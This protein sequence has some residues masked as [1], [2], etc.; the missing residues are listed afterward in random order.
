MFRI[1]G[2]PASPAL[3]R[4]PTA[5]VRRVADADKGAFVQLYRA[6]APEVAAHLRITALDPAN[7]AAITSATFVEVWWLARFH[8]APDTDVSAWITGIASRRAGERTPLSNSFHSV[9]DRRNELALGRLLDERVR[10]P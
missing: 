3:H 2:Q 7:A 6:F 10:V 1:A 5:L 9:H 4:G 8:T